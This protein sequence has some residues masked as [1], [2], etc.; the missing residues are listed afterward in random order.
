MKA[1]VITV[2]LL[3]VIFFSQAQS[4]HPFDTDGYYALKGS[5]ILQLRS[6]Q[7]KLGNHIGT[8]EFE[9]QNFDEVYYTL[10]SVLATGIIYSVK[11]KRLEFIGEVMNGKKH[12]LWVKCNTDVADEHVNQITE[13][14]F[15]QNGKLI[16]RKMKDL[17]YE[18]EDCYDQG[19]FD[20]NAPKQEMGILSDLNGFPSTSEEYF[21]GGALFAPNHKPFTGIGYVNESGTCFNLIASFKNGFKNGLTIYSNEGGYIGGFGKMIQDKQTGRWIENQYTG[22]AASVT[23]YKNNLL[24]GQVYFFSEDQLITT[25]SYL[26]GELL[27]CK[28]SCE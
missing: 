3:F 17:N 23:E 20:F 9:W 13:L 16:K 28:G 22:E 6:I 8:G 7:D 11:N 4:V 15:F 26:K 25:K 18:D 1:N 10:S 24:S 14:M 12:G 5:P 27:D 21:S 2:L 19:Y